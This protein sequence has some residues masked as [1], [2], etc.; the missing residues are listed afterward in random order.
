MRYIQILNYQKFNFQSSEI[1]Q[2]RSDADCQ[3]SVG[4]DEVVI[5]L[6]QI[7]KSPVTLEQYEPK[8][9]QVS[10]TKGNCDS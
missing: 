5:K 9:I 8:L 10:V 1:L 4:V 3:V 6:D 7:M 2:V